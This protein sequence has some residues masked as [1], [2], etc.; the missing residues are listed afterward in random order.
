MLQCFERKFWLFTKAILNKFI[1]K[2][3]SYK[4]ILNHA[5]VKDK[6]EKLKKKYIAQKK[7]KESLEA[8]L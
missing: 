8:H 2:T 4:P 1:G 5:Q 6:S 7:A 3:F